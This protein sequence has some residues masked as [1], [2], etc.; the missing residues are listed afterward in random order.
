MKAEKFRMLD[1]NLQNDIVDIFAP[2]HTDLRYGVRCNDA[3]RRGGYSFQ[4]ENK[5]WR[6][7]RC[8]LLD[9]IDDH[10]NVPDD[11]ELLL[12]IYANGKMTG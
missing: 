4:F 2:K 10:N 6:C 5:E 7:L 12:S 8:C 11:A 3:T 1:S 9:I